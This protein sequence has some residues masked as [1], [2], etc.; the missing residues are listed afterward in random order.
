MGRPVGHALSRL[1]PFL[2]VV[3]RR[4]YR[5]GAWD[6]ALFA[7]AW[8]R[9]LTG[10]ELV[11]DGAAYG[12]LAAGQALLAEAG[13]ADHVAYAAAHLTEVESWMRA[14]EGD[15]AVVMDQG[16]PCFGVVGSDV[17]HVLTPRGLGHVPLDAAVRVFR[18]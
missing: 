11:P 17:V 18:P 10:R 7:A 8:V 12:T 4:P 16:H 14:Q 6:C 1:T 13:H 5:P 9:E 3:A 2:A 15:I